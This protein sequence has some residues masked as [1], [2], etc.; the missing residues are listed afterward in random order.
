MKRVKF[1][2]NKGTQ[3]VV[4]DNNDWVAVSFRGTEVN[5]PID[6]VND[7]TFPLE[8]ELKGKV[9][10]GFQSALNAVWQSKGKYKGVEE[11][12]LK[13]SKNG[14]KPVFMTGHS[15]GAAI[16]IIAAA[17]WRR[18]YPLQGLY[19]FGSPGVGDK[20]FVDC[21]TNTDV[22]RI[23]HNEDM[24]TKASQHPELFHVGKLYM[25]D[26]NGKLKD[27]GSRPGDQ[28]KIMAKAGQIVL[29]EASR[30]RKSILLK[31]ARKTKTIEIPRCLADHS[32]K[33]Y[34]NYLRNNV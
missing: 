11:H 15:L 14:T 32:P 19:T 7:F 27:K 8:N 12:L 31:L 23:V 17:R 18:N 22:I 2:N 21:L 4:A 1:F 5:E 9:H 10:K 20:A 34:S 13:V 33:Y 24:V 29:T 3:C 26:A 25:I 28:D 16:A 6:V 30:I